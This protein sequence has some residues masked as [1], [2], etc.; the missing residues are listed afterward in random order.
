[1]FLYLNA[2]I[3]RFLYLDA[4]S[5]DVAN[6]L[7]QMVE[8][9][10]Q[11]AQPDWLWWLKP[12]TEAGCMVSCEDMT[13]SECEE[14][15]T[16]F[17]VVSTICAQAGVSITSS[18]GV[19]EFWNTQL[20]SPTFPTEHSE[21]YD[22]QSYMDDAECV[23]CILITRKDSTLRGADLNVM[24]D[25][26]PSLLDFFGGRE[27]CEQM[28]IPL[29]TGAVLLLDGGHYHAFTKVSGV[30]SMRYIKCVFQATSQ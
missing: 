10:V 14:H 30:G 26:T 27:E 16:L 29:H 11:N 24:L 2:H 23:V 19:V 13:P 28:E 20:D 9:R 12:P 6:Q 8:T 3:R 7:D 4:L 22:T 1:M 21:T 18:E 25:H 5:M 15:H 17:G